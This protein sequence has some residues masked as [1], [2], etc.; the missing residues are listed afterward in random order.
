MT[1]ETHVARAVATI[2]AG[3]PDYRV[4]VR[5]AG[6]ELVADEPADNGGA[7]A[8][9]SPF[10]Y[11]LS[12]LVSCTAITLRM[13]AQR[14]GWDCEPITVDARYDVSDTGERT[15]ARIITLPPGLDAD[16]R[17]RMAEIAE[18]TPV[19]KAVRAGTPITTALS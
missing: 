5:S 16:Q 14:K 8:G 17:A 11:L 9:P 3:S 18:K 13:Y 10:G 15:I 7:N 6:H 19:T 12:G 4:A 2:E 1:T